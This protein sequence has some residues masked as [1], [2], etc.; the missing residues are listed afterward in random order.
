MEQI[1]ITTDQ[2]SF[3]VLVRECP[4]LLKVKG[5]C[6]VTKDK[7]GKYTI[8][9]IQTILPQKRIEAIGFADCDNMVNNVCYN[10]NK[11][12]GRIENLPPLLKQL[13]TK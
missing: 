6:E 4:S 1:I 8:A 2:L 10:G 12:L 11:R 3:S 5:S 7:N 13:I 9:N